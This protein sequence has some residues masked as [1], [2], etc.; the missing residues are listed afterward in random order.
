MIPISDTPFEV[1]LDLLE[2]E[3]EANHSIWNLLSWYSKI[4]LEKAIRLNKRY[5]Q[6]LGWNRKRGFVKRILGIPH[7]DKDFW[8]AMA[9]AQFQSKNRLKVDGILGPKTWRK[10]KGRTSSTSNNAPVNIN[11]PYG[12][13]KIDTTIPDLSRSLP[14]Y[15]FT[16]EDAL[17]LARMVTGEAGTQNNADGH[18]VI[19][20]MFNRFGIFRHRVRSWTSFHHFLRQYSTPLQPSLKSVGAAKR[21]W[22]NHR[23]NPDKYPIVR[24]G[25]YY[26]NTD[27][28]R[29]IYKRHQ[30]LQRKPWSALDPK[31]KQMVVQILKGKIPNPGIGI[32]TE[33]LSTK[34]L[35][36]HKYGHTPSY[37]EWRNYTISYAKD[38][39]KKSARGCTWIGNR[40]NINQMKNAFFI[41]N[42]LKNVPS[43]AVKIIPP[44]P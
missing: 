25:G 8:L 19:W 33:F 43:D 1:N 4:D 3:Y 6:R 32:A 31:V 29:V 30:E 26:P 12:T 35:F 23:R 24:T 9:V 16:Q 5:G 34:I 13:L 15:Q 21:V 38:R 20:A 18:A 10:I 28:P 44:R 36:K 7:L 2:N 40:S 27:I 22:R 37:S 42:R 11:T 41:D 14:T 17:W 39:C